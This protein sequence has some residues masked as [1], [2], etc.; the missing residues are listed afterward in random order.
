[1][2]GI[3]FCIPTNGAKYRKTKAC[4]K[5]IRRSAKASGIPIQIIICGICDKFQDD[6]SLDLVNKNQ[7]AKT[8]KI[9]QMR[10]AAAAQ[11]QYDILVF[12]DDDFIFPSGWVSRFVEYDKNIDWQVTSTRILMPCGNRYWDRAIINPH[13]IVDYDH[14]PTDTNL[15]QTSGLILMKKNIWEKTPWDND[16]PITQHEDVLLS[17]RLHDSGIPL[18]FDKENYVWHWDNTCILREK[19]IEKRIYYPGHAYSVD[20]QFK[21]DLADIY[22]KQD[23]SDNNPQEKS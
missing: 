1:M 22:E 7:A 9:G 20:E 14:D 23:S 11:A 2:N 4:I 8:G 13:E 5:S 10:N 21:K 16:V 15:Y 18:L 12:V 3:T 17:L 19:R 6:I